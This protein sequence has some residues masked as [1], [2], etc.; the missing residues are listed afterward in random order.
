M[1]GF[2]RH[3]PLPTLVATVTVLLGGQGSAAAQETDT[4]WAPWVGCWQ[5]VAD[6]DA[7]AGAGFLCV[8]HAGAGVEV[9]E[10]V[11]GQARTVQALVADGRPYDVATEG[12]EGW[13]SVEFSLDGQRLYTRSEQACSGDPLTPSTGLIAMVSPS[14]WIDVQATDVNGRALSWARRY[15]PARP[16]PVEAAGFAD[17]AAERG[18][19]SRAAR[20]AASA[21]DIDDVL[22]ATRAVDAEAVRAWVAE[23]NDPFDLNARRLIRLADAGAPESVI[24]VM[25]AV[26]FP[27][28]FSID[29]QGNV[30]ELATSSTRRGYAYGGRPLLF[31]W[32]NRDPFYYSPFGYGYR[33]GYGYG[34]GYEY[35]YPDG[36]YSPGV[37]IVAPREDAEPKARVVRGRGYTRGRS[38]GTGSTSGSPASAPSVR[39]EGGGSSGTAEPS[40]S[41]A[42]S[43][44]GSSGTSEGR[45]AKPR[46]G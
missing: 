46:G 42:S 25:V 41:G 26:S 14:E 7:P 19:A 21:P 34:Y 31:G 6:E 36:Y 9:I 11:D 12:C 29:R 22:E 24:D 44:S 43:G 30:D 40:G 27:D 32:G 5:A 18:F 45:R 33:Y 35:G 20:A 3:F 38:N 4:R 37:V 39:R 28:R 16:E 8:R 17:L 10:V 2:A 1:T 15:R 13:R 23:L